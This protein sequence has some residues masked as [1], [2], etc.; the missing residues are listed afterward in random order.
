MRCQSQSNFSINPAVVLRKTMTIK[1][2][3]KKKSFAK[4][5]DKKSAEAEI[6]LK[7]EDQIMKEDADVFKKLAQ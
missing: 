4:D 6:I 5:Q 7:I 2:Q 1:P 3:S